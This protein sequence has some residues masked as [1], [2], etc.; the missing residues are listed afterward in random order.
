MGRRTYKTLRIVPLTE[1]NSGRWAIVAL[2]VV[3][4]AVIAPTFFLGQASGHDFEFHLASWMDAAR[5]W[6]EGVVFPRWAAWA[7]YDFG[8]PRFIFYPPV[9]WCLGAA[10]GL[11]LPWR[12]VPDAFLFLSIV[13][14]GASMHRLTRAWMPP[15][16]AVASAVIYA[17]NP[18][19]LVVVYL[20]SDF[21]E[22]LASAIFPLAVL[23]ALR[24]AGLEKPQAGPSNVR[25]P[26]RTIPPLALV[27]GAIWLTNAPAAV[28]TSYAL[29]LLLMLGAALRRSLAPLFTGAAALALGL[30]LA[31]VYLVPAALE[32]SWVNIAQA[33]SSGLRP[34]Q[35]FLFT[36]ILNPEHNFFNLTV[37]TVAMIAIGLAGI[38]AV[39]SYRGT[40]NHRAVWWTMFGLAAV[41]TFLMT[42]A[43]NIAWRFLPKLLF[44]QFPWRWLFPLGVSLAF[45]LGESVAASDRR[46]AL[47]LFW[48]AILAATAIGVTAGPLWGPW[49]DSD[50]VPTIS[51]AVQSGQGYEGVDEYYAHGGDRYDLPQEAPPVAL[52]AAKGAPQLL[53]AALGN[54]SVGIWEPEHKEFTV[55]ATQPV[56]AAVRLLSYP[57]WRVHVNGQPADATSDPDTSQMLVPLPAGQNRVEICFI[58]TADRTAGAALSGVAAIL[59][60]GMAILGRRGERRKDRALSATSKANG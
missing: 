57:A 43:S 59:L 31:G 9:S 58:S 2:I 51:A 53:G 8:E 42:P 18:Y 21:A 28:V 15:A 25:A 47:T 29:A 35:N 52:L 41:S 10:L 17:V 46:L 37:S 16:A 6:H 45:F 56:R 36:W 44:V 1:E 26:W 30:L 13:I 22:L 19:Q 48:V 40:R 33:L 55:D 50:D 24:S 4:L 23:F 3:A 49:W 12:V 20:R 34:D 14:A 60:A 38:G 39:L 32:Q 11:L 5:Q 27:Y 7:N 54:V